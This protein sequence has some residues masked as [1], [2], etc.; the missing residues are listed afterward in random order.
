[1]KT[2]YD[3]ATNGRRAY[4][5]ELLISVYDTSN[6]NYENNKS[7][8][9]VSK[10][11]SIFYSCKFDKR[12]SMGLYCERF[13]ELFEY[14]LLN[15]EF[16]FTPPWEKNPTLGTD[17]ILINVEK[18]LAKIGVDFSQYFG[19]KINRER[20]RWILYEAIVLYLLPAIFF[21]EYKD[22][23]NVNHPY[24][25]IHLQ[26]QA[27]VM[28]I[29]TL[30]DRELFFICKDSNI[31]KVYDSRYSNQACNYKLP[32]AISP[33]EPPRIVEWEN[34]AVNI[35]CDYEESYYTEEEEHQEKLLDGFKRVDEQKEEKI[36][37]SVNPDNNTAFTVSISSMSYEP[38]KNLTNDIEYYTYIN[39]KELETQYKSNTQLKDNIKKKAQKDISDMFKANENDYYRSIA[40]NIEGALD[41]ISKINIQLFIK[42]DINISKYQE[43][44]GYFSPEA[45]K[46][47]D[48]YMK[49]YGEE[50]CKLM[51][52]NK[53][54]ELIDCFS[55]QL[56][57][58]SEQLTDKYKTLLDDHCRDM[59]KKNVIDKYL[60]SAT[61]LSSSLKKVH[62]NLITFERLKNIVQEY[63][64]ML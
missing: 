26:I 13:R 64:D 43:A 2:S 16:E 54:I 47:V 57:A 12:K 48:F 17:S 29:Q 58:K 42:E 61:S 27:A 1:M 52:K 5:E 22:R 10:G 31:T 35:N 24:D 28:G 49:K 21:V 20:W 38:K 8:K 46:I 34:I 60:S 25:D 11:S 15:D 51:V 4:L 63:C 14:S 6:I 19:M 50:P 30:I 55:N 7:V 3:R 39:E 23:S 44:L 32:I 9:G 33:M 36:E 59:H 62:R 40:N 56:E 37:I 18:Y 41:R 45:D 53:L